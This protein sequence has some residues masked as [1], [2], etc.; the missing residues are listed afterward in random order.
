[1]GGARGEIKE[2]KNGKMLQHEKDIENSNFKCFKFV[3]LK[4]LQKSA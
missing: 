2:E 1:V 4:P 3:T